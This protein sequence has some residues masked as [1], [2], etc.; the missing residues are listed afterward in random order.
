MR[1][2]VLVESSPRHQP[3]QH[4]FNGSTNS[5]SSSRSGKNRS[6]SENDSSPPHKV[7]DSSSSSRSRLHPVSLN[8]VSRAID[9][10]GSNHETS[11]SEL[12]VVSTRDLK[13]SRSSADMAMMANDQSTNTQNHHHT[14]RPSSSDAKLNRLSGGP[15]VRQLDGRHIGLQQQK[16]GSVRDL[17]SSPQDIK[18]VSMW[19]VCGGVPAYPVGI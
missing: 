15:E 7:M 13:L 16:G 1:S 8:L 9:N 10:S 12:T 6:G 14:L 17:A 2:S 3:Q 19:S 18:L 11:S 5:S 4:T